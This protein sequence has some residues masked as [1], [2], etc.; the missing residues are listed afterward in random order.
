[1]PSTTITVA[2]ASAV[3]A[4]AA[5]AKPLF[6]LVSNRGA[7]NVPSIG[8]LLSKPRIMICDDDASL[9]ESMRQSLNG[10]YDV[11]SWRNGFDALSEIA[12]EHARGRSFD[13]LIVD[14]VMAQ[15]EGKRFAGIVREMEFSLPQKT[16]IVILTGMGRLIEKPP[17]VRAIWRKPEDVLNLSQKVR[18]ILSAYPKTV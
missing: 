18:E 15:I 3:A 16:P 7:R 5:A 4:I 11:S 1:M 10:G 17:G 2:I 13:L 8:V 12:R 6:E 9:L 14:L